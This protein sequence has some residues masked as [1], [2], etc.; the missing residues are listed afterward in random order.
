MSSATILVS[1]ANTH[2]SLGHVWRLNWRVMLDQIEGNLGHEPLET[3]TVE[4]GADSLLLCQVAG[5]EIA[6]V[7][8]VLVQVLGVLVHP[9][10]RNA[11]VVLPS[12]R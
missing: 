1:S 2:L 9:H 10:L 3:L 5:V 12:R 4:S 11:L 8:P 6:V 7:R